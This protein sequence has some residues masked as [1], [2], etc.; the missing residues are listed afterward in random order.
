MLLYRGRDHRGD[1]RHHTPFAG[2]Q[3]TVL[4]FEAVR[5]AHPIEI[6]RPLGFDGEGEGRDEFRRFAAD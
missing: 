4:A 2:G 5:A 1:G 3:R 6:E